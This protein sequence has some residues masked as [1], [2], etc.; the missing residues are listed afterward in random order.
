[1]NE[2]EKYWSLFISGDNDAL[3]K[4]YNLLFEPLVFVSFFG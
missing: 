4:L 3:G 1:M 2:E